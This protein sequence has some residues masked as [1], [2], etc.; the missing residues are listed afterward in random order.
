M[1][2]QAEAAHLKSAIEHAE[3]AKLVEAGEFSQHVV[4]HQELQKA[5][6]DR[7]AQIDGESNVAK[8]H[9]LAAQTEVVRL[10]AIVDEIEATRLQSVASHEEAVRL[11]YC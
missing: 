3:A 6:L 2:K 9:L 7:L 8:N 1:V 10:Q 4:S 11:R 5:E